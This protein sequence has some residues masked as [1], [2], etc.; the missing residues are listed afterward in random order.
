MHQSLAN[1]T[2]RIECGSSSG[3]GFSFIETDVIVTNNH[4]IA[5][6]HSNRQDI[7]AVT[8]NGQRILTELIAHS[9]ENQF[10][11]AVLRAKSP[12]PGG[13]HVL[14]PA[15]NHPKAR[16]T[17]VVFSGFPHGIH[18]LLTHEAVISGPAAPHSFYI[19][20]S[21]NGGNSGGPIIDSTSGEVIG[22]VTQRRFLGGAQLGDLRQQI[23]QLLQYCQG[24]ANRGSVQ[25]VGIDF[26]GFVQMMAQGFSIM[27]RIIQANANSG[28]GIGFGIEQVQQECAR[29]DIRN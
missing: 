26:G 1:A 7:E 29:L 12:V 24:I 22:I 27:D 25:I 28:I 13:R 11:F 14:K 3:S 17:K 2:F 6:Y 18:D 15:F 23:S 4:V 19:D 10:D 21:V 8:E 5:P 20:G 16:G 9:P